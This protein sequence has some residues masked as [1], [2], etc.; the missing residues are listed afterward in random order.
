M[1]NV[2]IHWKSY[3]KRSRTLCAE[4]NCWLNFDF[5]TKNRGKERASG[6]QK[7]PP[8]D[9]NSLPCAFDNNLPSLTYIPQKP[10]GGSLLP[11]NASPFSTKHKT[12][13][14]KNDSRLDYLPNNQSTLSSSNTTSYIST[15]TPKDKRLHDT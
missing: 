9:L 5:K 1:I 14:T 10:K 4:C 2:P 13:Q 11:T 15:Q 7:I 12:Q 6:D 8:T 3:K